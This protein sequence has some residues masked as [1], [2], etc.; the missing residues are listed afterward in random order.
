M[1]PARRRG[2]QVEDLAEQR[3]G[4]C[5][6]APG[7]PPGSRPR[8]A[9]PRAQQARLDGADSAPVRP[10][11]RGGDADAQVPDLA[12]AQGAAG[13]RHIELAGVFRVRSWRH[14]G[15]MRPKA[16]HGARSRAARSRCSRS[17]PSRPSAAPARAR[18]L[19][20]DAPSTRRR[21]AGVGG[22]LGRKGHVA[23]FCGVARPPTSRG[24]A[25]NRVT[26]ALLNRYKQ[27]L[28]SVGQSGLRA[29]LRPH[30]CRPRGSCR[31]LPL[32]AS[33]PLDGLLQPS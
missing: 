20:R 12:A 16:T 10:A 9:S 27:L 8:P 5:S 24:H 26:D 1:Q 23:T 28:S 22:R 14:P 19:G 6:R 18:P 15:R 29:D 7:R 13:R 17:P 31:N 32:D 21:C 33:R 3:S 11:A 2:R 25:R 30:Q 4:A